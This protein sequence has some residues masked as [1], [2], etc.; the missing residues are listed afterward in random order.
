MV[1]YATL[2]F[3]PIG[4]V[5]GD[6]YGKYNAIEAGVNYQFAESWKVSFAYNMVNDES[7]DKGTTNG[8]SSNMTAVGIHVYW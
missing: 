5:T 1:P 2:G 7:L 3:G 8:H 4:Y 6:K